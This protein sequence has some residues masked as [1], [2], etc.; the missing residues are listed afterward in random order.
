MQE[1]RKGTGHGSIYETRW[2]GLGTEIR[3]IAHEPVG[4]D[5]KEKQCDI[6]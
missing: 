4:H 3:G 6:L 1:G 5:E 2:L